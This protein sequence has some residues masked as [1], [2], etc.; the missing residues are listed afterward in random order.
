MI[1][2]IFSKIK[3][4]GYAILGFLVAVLYALFQSERAKVARNELANKKAALEAVAKSTKALDDAKKAGE[5]LKHEVAE[6]LDN[7]DFSDLQR[8]VRK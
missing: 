1:S 7:N 8:G 3:L 5:E 6:H 2:M 4:Y